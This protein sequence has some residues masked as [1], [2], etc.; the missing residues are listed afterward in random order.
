MRAAGLNQRGM[1]PRFQR[2]VG[3]A[4]RP[5]EVRIR[6]AQAGEIGGDTERL[7][8]GSASSASCAS[9]PIERMR[10]TSRWRVRLGRDHAQQRDLPEP[11]RPTRPSHAPERKRQSV[12]TAD[13]HQGGEGNR[14][15][16]RKWRAWRVSGNGQNRAR[17]ACDVHFCLHGFDWIG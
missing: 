13:V 1:Q 16:M 2:P 15:R 6:D 8:D 12:E 7:R 11:L 3:S 4:H 17:Q 10:R 14:I 9:M 5:S